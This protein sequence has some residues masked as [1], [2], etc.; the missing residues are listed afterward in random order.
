[1]ISCSQAVAQLWEYLAE[2]VTADDRA[3]VEEHLAFCRRCCGEAEFAEE[4][5]GVLTGAADT[6]LPPGV[7]ARLLGVLEELEA[8]ARGE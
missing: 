3:A 6:Q 7:E 5:H 1:M 2:E 8:G 4:L